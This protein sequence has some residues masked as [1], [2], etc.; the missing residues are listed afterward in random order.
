MSLTATTRRP[1]SPTGTK[2]ATYRANTIA[3]TAMIPVCIVQNIAQPQRNA[4]PGENAS[5]KKTYT[6]PTCGYA[7]ASSAAINAPNSVRIPDTI[8]TAYTAVSVGTV[9]V[10]TD[11]CTKIDAPM[12]IPTTS[13]VACS[14]VIERESIGRES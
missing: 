10:I 3:M 5:R 8:H 11:G 12:M 2:K 13:A 14:G 6:P 4:T 9:P 7:E 1:A